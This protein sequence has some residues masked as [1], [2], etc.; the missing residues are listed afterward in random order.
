VKMVLILTAIGHISA[1]TAT[2][3]IAG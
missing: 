2:S 3:S 1:C